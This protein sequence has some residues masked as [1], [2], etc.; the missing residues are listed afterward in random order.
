MNC[1]CKG[2]MHMPRLWPLSQPRVTPVMW[3]QVCMCKGTEMIQT[4]PIQPII[5][6]Q[7]CTILFSKGLGSCSELGRC[8]PLQITPSQPCFGRNSKIK[9]K[10]W[11]RPP[12][13]ETLRG[14]PGLLLV[15][16][17]AQRSLEGQWEA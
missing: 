12:W 7:Y 17:L 16:F 15:T 8:F 14:T 10:E 9:A 6:Q 13:T 2:G 1:K 11:A 5:M 3:V 4:P